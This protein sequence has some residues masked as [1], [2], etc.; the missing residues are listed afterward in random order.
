MM[1]NRTRSTLFKTCCYLFGIFGHANAFSLT[2]GKSRNYRSALSLSDAPAQETTTMRSIDVTVLDKPM[3]MV[4][5]EN[6]ADEDKGV[7]CLECDETSAA[8]AAGVREGDII[9]SLAE[10]DVT[11]YTFEQAMK[12]LRDCETPLSM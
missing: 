6:V 5:G 12:V 7:Y 8:F 4:L 1:S 3:G 10:A 11:S 9:A 2:V